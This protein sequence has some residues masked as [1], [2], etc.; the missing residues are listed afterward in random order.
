MAK[1]DALRIFCVL[2]VLQAAVSFRSVPR[3]LG[4]S[5]NQGLMG[6]CW[7]P[8]FTSVINWSLRIGLGLLKQV[9]PIDT[10]WMAIIDHSIDVGTKKALVV[11]RVPLAV[12]A[13]RG[14]AVRLEDCQCIGL[15]VA[16]TVN[17][18]TVAR[19][20]EAIFSR[21]GPPAAITQD[22]DATLN[23]GVRLWMN[24]MQ[25]QAPVIED[26]SHVMAG[27]LKA[28]FERTPH[29]NRFTAL[30]TQ[31]AKA[32]RQ[33]DLAF[34]VP[35][36]LRTKGRFLNIGKLARWGEKMLDALAVKGRAKKGS[37]LEK[38][39]AA[40]PGFL[41]LRPFITTFAATAVMVCQVM[42]MLKN[43]GLDS[44]TGAQCRQ[45][46]DQLP[47]DSL[48][49][50]R[51]HTWLDRH[52]AIQRQLSDLP[53]IVSSDVIESLFGKFKYILE[54]SPQADMNRTTLLLPALCGNP[55]PTALANAL[56]QT[57]HRDLA[58]WEAKHIPYTQ[59]KKRAS[60]FSRNQSQ[61][62]GNISL[63]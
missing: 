32:L 60:F 56:A 13:Q 46:A 48:V 8:H 25:L 38:L 33:T 62:P 61:K 29:Y 47:A 3:I 7:V 20:L 58:G 45:L 36:K 16:E 50:Q 14:S 22:C 10:P 5:Q 6:A 9:A 23:K 18:A 4:L 55:D 28:Q 1:A 37:V 15:V 2:L 24:K 40:L 11:L 27:A 41:K 39:R 59:R 57:S 51:L 35:P 44:S 52:G 19:Q 21:S 53:L 12:L 31:A 43:K 30:S 26:I 17:G 54:R 34:L 49:R 42:A 63:E